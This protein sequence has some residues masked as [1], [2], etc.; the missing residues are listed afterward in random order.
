M[1]LE[2]SPEIY[3]MSVDTI[4]ADEISPTKSEFDFNNEEF[5]YQKALQRRIKFLTSF[6][7]SDVQDGQAPI[8]P[9]FFKLLIT[10]FSFRQLKMLMLVCKDWYNQIE[11]YFQEKTWL[12]CSRITKTDL[13]HLNK[14][15]RVYDKL[16]I[17]KNASELE[18][19]LFII[20]TRKV[21]SIIF[22]D[23]PKVDEI[24][25][26]M[27]EV[28]SLKFINIRGSP[29]LKNEV[30]FPKRLKTL[31]FKS[32]EAIN[33]IPALELLIKN[34]VHLEELELVLPNTILNLAFL[35]TLP[36]L[37]KFTLHQ[38]QYSQWLIFLTSS[39]KYLDI[40]LTDYQVRDP[41]MSQFLGKFTDLKEISIN[42]INQKNFN[43][44]WMNESVRKVSF[45]NITNPYSL[46]RRFDCNEAHV[47][48]LTMNSKVV[49][50]N[51]M[52]IIH[53]SMPNLVYLN[54][55]S[56]NPS[57][58]ST[59]FFYEVACK[60]EKLETLELTN[61]VITFSVKK[62]IGNRC[63]PVPNLRNLCL[64]E[65]E[66]QSEFLKILN[67][68]KLSSLTILWCM[69][70]DLRT[71]H[72]LSSNRFT[73]HNLKHVHF[74]NISS[75]ILF[76]V[77]EELMFLESFKAS[78][79]LNCCYSSALEKIF[80]ISKKVWDLDLVL[81]GQFNID[82]FKRNLEIVLSK[83]DVKLGEFL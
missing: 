65:C 36:F 28:T 9:E 39:V 27:P 80:E 45:S 15:C 13:F 50:D 33:G 11:D 57:K 38:P 58:I 71:L 35:S 3:D 78:V 22:D 1:D 42:F 41:R 24:L 75:E 8:P 66:Y 25:G 68:P 60:L 74:C 29:I 19:I 7:E 63:N 14:S 10:Q 69:E 48:S 72:I 73:F 59:V 51:F 6:D 12:N 4:N 44:L 17:D 62:K 67:A 2:A 53:D 76:I 82:F 46:W 40:N 61:F 37:K 49:T 34:N 16:M 55:S 77:H 64:Y 21:T 52:T 83:E 20:D 81:L 56:E 26:K 31:A 47:T 79:Q 43:A 70:I 54:I 5:Q 30:R 32:S 18:N 23:F